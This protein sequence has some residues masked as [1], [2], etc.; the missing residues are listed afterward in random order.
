MRTLPKRSAACYNF[1][2]WKFEWENRRI[3]TQHV[4]FVVYNE[5]KTTKNLVLMGLYIYIYI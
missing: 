5:V 2:D 3:S 1:P 4:F